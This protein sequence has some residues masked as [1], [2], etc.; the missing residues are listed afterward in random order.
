MTWSAMPANVP[1]NSGGTT[2]LR[3]AA[4]VSKRPI[5]RSVPFTTN[6]GAFGRPGDQHKLRIG[7]VADAKIAT[8]IAG[9]YAH[10]I[11]GDA[12]R[13]GDVVPLTDHAVA[14]AGVDGEVPRRRIVRTKCRAQFHRH[15]S[16]AVYRRLQP[17]NMCCPRK[18][19]FGRFSIAYLR[20]DAQVRVTLRPNR[21]CL[22]CQC[23]MRSGYGGEW[24]VDDTDVLRRIHRFGERFRND[25]GDRL[26][27][28]AYGV[29]SE[30]R[31]GRD[32]EVGTVAI[33]Y[34]YLVRV[35]RHRAVR[36]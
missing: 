33:P 18:R 16:D 22:R 14:G 28:V 10:R 31:M 9:N 29:Y 12:E 25:D 3:V 27:D 26:P 30:N 6:C 23:I 24:P 35:G 21:Q 8:D 17:H 19:G 1:R 4:A 5:E 20:V 13:A 32:K 2:S 15:P 34:R 11:F 7:V 36:D